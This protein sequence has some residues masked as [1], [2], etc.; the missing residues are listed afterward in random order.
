M[1]ATE[2]SKATK[3]GAFIIAALLLTSGAAFFLYVGLS[4]QNNNS[5]NNSNN[6]ETIV[7]DKG[8]PEIFVSEEVQAKV[9][10][11]FSTGIVAAAV[12]SPN[13]TELDNAL[14]NIPNVSFLSSEVS[15]L[16]AAQN[17][18]LY[19]AEITLSEGAD[20][21]EFAQNVLSLGLLES[22]ELFFEASVLVPKSVNAQNKE[23]KSKTVVL[24]DTQIMG[25]VS[26]NTFQENTVSGN[27]SIVLQD[28]QVLQ[29]FLVENQ[30]IS[31]SPRPVTVETSAVISK[32]L[33]AVT[34]TGAIPF[35]PGLSMEL[36]END[37]E[38]LEG[39]ESVNPIAVPKINNR[40]IVEFD[41]AQDIADELEK[42]I[43]N[44]PEKFSS[45][46]LE[47]YGFS[48]DLNNISISEA[49]DFVNTKVDELTFQNNELVFEDPVTQFW[50]D[51][52]TTQSQTAQ[53]LEAV[54]SYFNSSHPGSQF[55]IFQNGFVSLES[56]SIPDSNQNYPVE[57][58]QV[59]VS[60]V[61]G[62][63]EGETVPIQFNAIIVQE[64]IVNIAG[65]EVTAAEERP[66]QV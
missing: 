63:E 39:I 33:P 20:R 62:H 6:N 48:V 26:P 8:T 49:K 42:S 64:E 24:P 60:L 4:D 14:R 58:G 51:G 50:L 36:L 30:N 66:G 10:S 5:S 3:W 54:S 35:S 43:L 19:R 40:L 44:E 28:E 59:A 25:F 55:E 45:F 61:P 17:S 34:I 46:S 65:L 29:T 18:H 41:N 12:I 15:V 7:P 2:P 11:V 27:I 22:P 23:G 53:V 52:N 31:L 9:T 32:L 47:A 13:K 56:I 21:A 57:S 1:P 16:D 38:A 37:L